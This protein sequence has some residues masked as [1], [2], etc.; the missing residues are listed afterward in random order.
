MKLSEAMMEVWAEYRKTFSRKHIV[1]GL[2]QLVVIVVIGG[3]MALLV[4][5]A[6]LVSLCSGFALLLWVSTIAF[7]FFFWMPF[8]VDVT[9]KMREAC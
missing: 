3:P 9:R 4:P 2:R 1:E 6:S 7:W 5:I 8:W